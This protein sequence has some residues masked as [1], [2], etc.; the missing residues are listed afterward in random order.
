M[1]LSGKFIAPIVFAVIIGSVSTASSQKSLS[2]QQNIAELMA[3]A[4]KNFDLSKEDAVILF[5][6][7]K[8]YW[9]PDGRLIDFNHEIIWINT[10]YAVNHYGDHRIPYDSEHCDFKVATVR[11]WRDSQWWET[12]ET[13]IVETLPYQLNKAYDY[14]NVREMM[15]LHN[16]IEIPCILE[17]AYYIE[18]KEPFR[19]GIDGIWSFAKH[20]PVVWSWFGY[21][22][23]KGEKPQIEVSKEI[24]KPEIE[25]DEKYGLDVYWW[26]AG[27]YDAIVHSFSEN[28]ASDVP[29]IAW[30]DWSDWQA[31]GDFISDEIIELAVIDS[32]VVLS[33]DSVLADAR[34]DSEKAGL[35][36]DYIN[37]KTR[38]VDYS[39]KF[40]S[41]SPRPA[42]RTYDTAYGYKFDRAI[43]G[44]A[45]F[46]SAGLVTQPVYIGNGIGSYVPGIPTTAAMSGI[47]LWLEGDN[48][49]GIYNPASGTVTIAN[50]KIL[51]RVVWYP[52]N[53]KDPEMHPGNFKTSSLDVQIDLAYDVK[54][55]KLTGSGIYYADN[56][57]SPYGEMVGVGDEAKSYLNKTISSVLT[58]AKVT[59]FNPEIFGQG[60]VKC[61][62][63]FEIEKLELDDFG[64]LEI[65][66]GEP[67]G[68]IL[69][70]LPDGVR[71]TDQETRRWI[72]LP[73]VLN[74]NIELKLKLDDLKLIYSPEANEFK[75]DC[76]NFAVK[77]NQDEKSITLTR[78]LSVMKT[79][80]NP[81]EWPCLRKLLLDETGERNNTIIVKAEKGNPDK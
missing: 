65:E 17:V 32:A 24:G 73:S 30:S 53:D 36:A 37:D 23:A 69:G 39:D 44:K 13:G 29:Y 49:E 81:D 50:P 11:T 52:G 77:V 47:Y 70:Y 67:A 46:E 57:F 4:Q 71:L 60:K 54:A 56:A 27:P 64:R 15:L 35:I 33:V 22:V 40:W 12:G 1:R 38:L 66:M 9:L 3:I 18:D 61:G 74:Q 2:G 6:G 10:D 26:K 48:F 80:Y 45:L 42:M 62:F 68:G 34:T 59:N 55:D 41:D 28:P 51:N 75:D 25:S 5:E 8:L 7:K 16:G 43:F 31:L 76:G 72:Y 14:S 79:D 21:G 63:E 19:D 20:D 58:G 78:S